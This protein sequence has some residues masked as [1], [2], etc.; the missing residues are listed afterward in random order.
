MMD[1]QL[2]LDLPSA[3]WHGVDFGTCWAL[4]QCPSPAWGQGSDGQ[5]RTAVSHLPLECPCPAVWSSCAIPSGCWRHCCR[6]VRGVRLCSAVLFSITGSEF[7]MNSA[8]HLLLVVLFLHFRVPDAPSK[9]NEGGASLVLWEAE[10]LRALFPADC[11][12]GSS[13]PLIPLETFLLTFPTV[14]CK[15]L[16][17]L[18]YKS[19]LSVGFPFSPEERWMLRYVCIGRILSKLGQK[20]LITIGN[21]IFFELKSPKEKPTSKALCFLLFCFFN[22]GYVLA[23]FQWSLV[24][25]TFFDTDLCESSCQT[26]GNDKISKLRQR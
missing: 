22:K 20:K 23:V 11:A 10:M 25:A 12:L 1:P 6:D 9:C 4:P 2:L 21:L 7:L 14:K 17:S 5:G 18:Q 15:A 16:L 19:A 26:E 13:S 24:S 3:A 8:F